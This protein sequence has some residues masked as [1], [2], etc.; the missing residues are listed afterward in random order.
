MGR[1]LQ[2][3]GGI[4][5]NVLEGL[6]E[7]QEHAAYY[8]LIHERERRNAEAC[9]KAKVNDLQGRLRREVLYYLEVG[10]VDFWMNTKNLVLEDRRPLDV[11][12]DEAGLEK[13]REALKEIRRRRR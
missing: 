9:Q 4:S 7:D 12:I 1:P 13:C 8:E 3:L 10:Q 5:I 11:C 6:S 2:S